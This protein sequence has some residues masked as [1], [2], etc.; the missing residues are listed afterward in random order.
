MRFDKTKPAF[1]TIKRNASRN[2]VW[3]IYD[4]FRSIAQVK[5]RVKTAYQQNAMVPCREKLQVTVS[6]QGGIFKQ[7]NM[8]S[9]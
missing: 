8:M 4:D 7:F 9:I 2:S 1:V 3:S 5:N 6:Q